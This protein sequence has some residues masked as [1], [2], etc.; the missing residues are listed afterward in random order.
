MEKF[1]KDE[2]NE[3]YVC[4]VGGG[5]G[6]NGDLSVID[7]AE[8]VPNECHNAVG[9]RIPGDTRAYAARKAHRP[10]QCGL[11][12]LIAIVPECRRSVRNVNDHETL[13][14]TA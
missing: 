5:G 6:D 2:G 11:F 4:T 10:Q 7:F 8:M 1:E 13:H 3:R 9:Y 14:E 12:G